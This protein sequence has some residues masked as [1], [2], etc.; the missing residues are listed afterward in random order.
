MKIVY[1]LAFFIL[2]RVSVARSIRLKKSPKKKS[3]KATYQPPDLRPSVS[4]SFVF[5]DVEHAESLEQIEAIQQSFNDSSIEKPDLDSITIE[6]FDV[7]LSAPCLNSDKYLFKHEPGKTCKWIRNKENRRQRLC[8]NPEVRFNCPQSCGL[9]CDD[10]PNY[11]F[12]VRNVI[13]KTC[14]WIAE[15]TL[16]ERFCDKFRNGRMVRDACPRSCN[17][18]PRF[19]PPSP[20]DS[21]EENVGSVEGI[22]IESPLLSRPVCEDNTNYT[23]PFQGS[24]GCDLVAGTDCTLWSVF[25]NDVQMSELYENCPVSCGLCGNPPNGTESKECIDDN[26]YSSPVNPSFGC[27]I[28]AGTNCSIWEPMLNPSQ[29]DDMYSRCPVSCTVPCSASPSFLPTYNPSSSPT[30]FPSVVPSSTPSLGYFS[31]EFPSFTPSTSKRPSPFPSD[32][33]TVSSDPSTQRSENPTNSIGPTFGSVQPSNTPSVSPSSTPTSLQS[34]HPSNSPT[35]ALL[36]ET[37]QPTQRPCEKPIESIYLSRIPS[38]IPSSLT[39][40]PTPNPSTEP[41]LEPSEKVCFDDSTY[42]SPINPIFDCSLHCGTDCMKWNVLLTRSQLQELLIRCPETC[43][44]PCNYTLPSTPPHQE[45]SSPPS[46]STINVSQNPSGNSLNETNIT[47][48]D[49][50]SSMPSHVDSIVRTVSPSSV[51]T[52]IPSKNST[53]CIDDATAVFRVNSGSLRTCKWLASEIRR[54]KRY[55]SDN[56]TIALIIQSTCCETC[57]SFVEI[58]PSTSPSISPTMAKPQTIASSS[59]SALLFQVPGSPS[60]SRSSSPTF[61]PSQVVSN[62][63][64]SQ[65]PSHPSICGLSHGER[66]KNIYDIIS[67]IS[68]PIALEDMSS[69][70]GKALDWIINV[71]QAYLCPETI[72]TCPNALIQRYVLA[73][74]YFSTNGDQW[75]QCSASL[76]ALDSCG[77]EYPFSSKTRFLDSGSECNWAG[78]DCNESLCVTRIEFEDN[79]LN[80][81]IPNEIGSLVHLEFWGMERGRLTSTI[82]SSISS[83][84]NLYFLDLDFNQLTGEIP[85]EMFSLTNLRQLDLNSNKLEGQLNG[86]E[87]L[88]KLQFL[89]FHENMFTGQI[90]SGLSELFELRVLTTY[91]N[92]FNSSMPESI[93]QHRD[94]NGGN[95]TTLIADCP[96]SC[97]TA[98]FCQ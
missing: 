96:C 4:T 87:R 41:S 30:S 49:P 8:K 38:S 93:C 66:N 17:F 3:T 76:S 10:D 69:P 14:D 24:C 5:P 83:L 1:I 16:N 67:L 34:K 70:Q 45:P 97:C 33:P 46:L 28:Y 56:T 36:I 44:V 94:V 6:G 12:T 61:E 40:H 74:I 91:L 85:K 52:D 88:T 21:S 86:L 32:I 23:T 47:H 82:P 58:S 92:Q 90:P 37:N 7:P 68:D 11:N 55:C 72:Y 50:P 26:S 22:F 51:S 95:L 13:T 63:M 53:N 73:V 48:S 25:L 57:D 31:S 65:I 89:Q 80:G 27:E 71:D 15:D 62:I 20:P 64:K 60:I 84:S 75:F 98:A 19:I 59:P 43:K 35:G 2:C 77:E 9:C 54:Q 78:I 79:N 81:V 18:C 29:I 39:K 42:R